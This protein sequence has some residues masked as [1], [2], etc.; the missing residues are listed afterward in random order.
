YSTV[1][2]PSPAFRSRATSRCRRGLG[3]RKR[4]KTEGNKGPGLR[5][6]D[7]LNRSRIASCRSSAE[8]LPKYETTLQAHSDGRP[9]G[10]RLS[11]KRRLRDLSHS[12]NRVSRASV[13]KRQFGNEVEV[14]DA[15]RMGVWDR[16]RKSPAGC[17]LGRATV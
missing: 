8:I 15:G 7:C 17:G 4:P 5:A 14:S 13:P 11:W 9:V 6:R 2:I 1:A 10:V 12:R 16:G 3:G